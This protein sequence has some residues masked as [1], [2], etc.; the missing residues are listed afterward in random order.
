MVKSKSFRPLFRLLS[1]LHILKEH[2]SSYLSMLLT[3][4]DMFSEATTRKSPKKARETVTKTAAKNR[5][6]KE[7]KAK[8][9]QNEATL[10]YQKQGLMKR[11]TSQC[12]QNAY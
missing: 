2:L 5:K 8:V 4:C 10:K 7:T 3:F 6:R 12:V 11:T 1:K 9:A